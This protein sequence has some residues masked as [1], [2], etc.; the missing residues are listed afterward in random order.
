VRNIQNYR[1]VFSYFESLG[2]EEVVPHKLSIEQKIKVFGE[3]KIIVGPFSSGFTNIV[4]CKPGVQIFAFTNYARCYDSYVSTLSKVW[5][6]E[7][8]LITG[9]DVDAGANSNYTINISDIDYYFKDKFP[10]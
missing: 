2:F 10:V 5:D 6:A 8:T 1:E 7:L 4:F 9:T 3:A